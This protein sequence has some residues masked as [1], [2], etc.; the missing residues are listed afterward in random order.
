M[1][2]SVRKG[3][4]LVKI[5]LKKPMTINKKVQLI[6]IKRRDGK[7]FLNKF[8]EIHGLGKNIKVEVDSLPKELSLNPNFQGEPYEVYDI[9]VKA[10]G[11][12]T[13]I[14][15]G[16]QVLENVVSVQNINMVPLKPGMPIDQKIVIEIPKH[17]LVVD[18]KRSRFKDLVDKI[19]KIL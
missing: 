12:A 8:F 14:V 5:N 9:V 11:F 18:E 4:I 19:R 15:K 6:V 1:N 3:I 2:D 10:E 16:V 7:V 13:I 17:N